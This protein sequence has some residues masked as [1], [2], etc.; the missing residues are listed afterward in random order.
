MLDLTTIDQE[1]IIARGQ[2]SSVNGA[3]KDAKRKLALQCSEFQSIAALVLRCMQ[4]DGDAM[5]DME[6][7]RERLTRGRE[8]LAVID[9]GAT[10]IEELALQRA[11]L[12]DAAWGR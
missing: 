7:V 5:P 10:E 11:S 3:L 4:P 2:Y 8:L 1:T 9:A 6:V 12:K